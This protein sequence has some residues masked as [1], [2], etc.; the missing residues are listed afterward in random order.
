ML[1][2]PQYKKILLRLLIIFAKFLFYEPCQVRE[3]SCE[4]LIPDM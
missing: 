2:M 3:L 4:E 1:N